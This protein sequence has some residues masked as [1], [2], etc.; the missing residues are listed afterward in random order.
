MIAKLGELAKL[1][2][3]VSVRLA[4]TRRAQT[5]DERGD[6]GAM[7]AVRERCRTSAPK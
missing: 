6:I 7:V 5:N 3:G 1:G 2:N 4:P